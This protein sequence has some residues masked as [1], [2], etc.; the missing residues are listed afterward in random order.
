VFDDF[1]PTATSENQASEHNRPQQHETSR[2]YENNPESGSAQ[3]SKEHKNRGS[4][5][6]GSEEL[7]DNAPC[8]NVGIAA[9]EETSVADPPNTEHGSSSPQPTA[10]LDQQVSRS[11]RLRR[12]PARLDDYIC[13]NSRFQDPLSLAHRLQQH[14]S[15]TPYPIANYVTSA[16]FSVSY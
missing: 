9:H 14:S 5:V 2:E 11:S 16:N 10:D 3:R 4:R 12:P 6:L 1:G 15:G 8:R 7:Q 13:Y